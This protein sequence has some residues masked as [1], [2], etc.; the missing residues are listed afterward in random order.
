M[1]PAFQSLVICL[2]IATISRAVPVPEG[3]VDHEIELEDLE[4][5]LAV[6]NQ[7]DKS[8]IAIAPPPKDFPGERLVSIAPAP[9]DFPGERLTGGAKKV[10]DPSIGTYSFR[11]S[12]FKEKSNASMRLKTSN[13][14]ERDL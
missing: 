13:C 10:E 3:Q 8:I 4:D 11:Y 12:I 2:T 5:L 1:S 9:K 6:E 14:V 7:I